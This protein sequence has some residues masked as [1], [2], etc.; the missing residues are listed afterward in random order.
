MKNF[1]FGLLGASG[2]IDFTHAFVWALVGIAISLLLGVA[3]RDPTSTTSP[4]SFSWK[5]ML[6]D[7]ARRIVLTLL[8]VIACVRFTP[9]LF[10][11]P[12]S[13]FAGFCIGLGFDQ[14][15]ALLKKKLPGLFGGIQS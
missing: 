13:A 12:L 2:P 1:L 14:L 10:G 7:N 3:K 15:A 9:E 8:L 4:V 5:H 6:L 11:K